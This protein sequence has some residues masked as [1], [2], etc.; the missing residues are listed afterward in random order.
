MSPDKI[1]YTVDN[2]SKFSKKMNLHSHGFYS[3]NSSKTHIYNKGWYLKNI[4]FKDANRKVLF[5][6]VE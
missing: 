2:V 6:A 3:L 4:L 5:K 1:A